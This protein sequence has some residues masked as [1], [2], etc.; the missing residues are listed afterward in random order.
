M[1]IIKT[2]EGFS[3][4]NNDMNVL[5]TFGPNEFEKFD[6]LVSKWESEN[7]TKVLWDITTSDKNYKNYVNGDK[8]IAVI[9]DE[10]NDNLY[11]VVFNKNRIFNSYDKLDKE[12]SK[13]IFKFLL[14]E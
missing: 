1:K 10:K 8:K 12:V 7:K 11:G 14:E 2:F 4:E 13:D 6:E 3:K 9:E 5:G